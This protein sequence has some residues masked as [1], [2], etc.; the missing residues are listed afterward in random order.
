MNPAILPSSAL[1]QEFASGGDWLDMLRASREL[2]HACAVHSAWIKAAKCQETILGMADLTTCRACVHGQA[3]ALACPG[4]VRLALPPTSPLPD[5]GAA[6]APPEPAPAARLCGE[7]QPAAPV[8]GPGPC[9]AASSSAGGPG[10]TGRKPRPKT[11]RAELRRRRLERKRK[12]RADA[13]L[14]RKE[15]REQAKAARMEKKRR[16]DERKAADKARKAKEAQDSEQGRRFSLLAETLAYLIPRHGD[17]GTLGL[18]FTRLIFADRT[19]LDL[20]LP[21]FRAL[22]EAAGLRVS[23]RGSLVI[24]L[25]NVALALAGLDKEAA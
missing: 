11:D 20:A 1:A 19:G 14:Q 2:T 8:P 5:L 17:K 25:D 10:A 18:R 16:E 13:A 4:G 22:C 3:L 15:E 12:A 24:E 21:E 9:T 7:T 23:G 6:P